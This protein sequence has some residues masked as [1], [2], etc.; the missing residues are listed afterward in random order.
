MKWFIAQPGVHVEKLR[1]GYGNAKQDIMTTCQGEYCK[2]PTELPMLQERIITVGFVGRLAPMKSPGSIILV[3]QLVKATY[4]NIRFLIIGGGNTAFVNSLKR[5]AAHLRVTDIIE[6]TGPVRL[7]QRVPI[8]VLHMLYFI[9]MLLRY[10]KMTY[11]L[12]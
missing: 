5:L 12:N 11:Q 10:L 7:I 4:P 8:S 6:F 9:S 2:P 3:A 1:Q